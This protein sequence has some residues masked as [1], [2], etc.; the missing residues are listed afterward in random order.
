[1]SRIETMR[2]LKFHY[3]I[4]Y[5]VINHGSHKI[6]DHQSVRKYAIVVY[7]V[8]TKVPAR[9]L[10]LFV[11]RVP[12]L[13]VYSILNICQM[14]SHFCIISKTALASH[15]TGKLELSLILVWYYK[16]IINLSYLMMLS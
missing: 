12:A 11:V 13:T 9:Y 16:G 7:Q 14:H 1:M 10:D 8:L 6:M 2:S 15:V 3:F 4:I 5:P